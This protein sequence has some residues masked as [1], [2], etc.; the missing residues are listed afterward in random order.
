MLCACNTV[1]SSAVPAAAHFDHLSA[2]L[3]TETLFRKQRDERI[4]WEHRAMKKRSEPI[5]TFQLFLQP[6]WGPVQPTSC[7]VL[8]RQHMMV[9]MNILAHPNQTHTSIPLLRRPAACLPACQAFAES[10]II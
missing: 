2:E 7:P 8:S 1:Q 4:D 5:L 10:H 9:V 3:H 6:D